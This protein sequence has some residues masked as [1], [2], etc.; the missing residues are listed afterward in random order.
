[1]I[2][3]ADG[4]IF[5]CFAGAKMQACNY[6]SKPPHSA[7]LQQLKGGDPMSSEFTAY[8]VRLVRIEFLAGVTA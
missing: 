6:L 7:G 5:P 8:A 4:M 3:S 2:R 1:M